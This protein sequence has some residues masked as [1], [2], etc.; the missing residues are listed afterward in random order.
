MLNLFRRI[1]F[2][3]AFVGLLFYSTAAFARGATSLSRDSITVTV[4]ALAPKDAPA[5]VIPQEDVTAFSGATRLKVTRWLRAQANEANLQLAVLIDNDIGITM[6]GEQMQDLANFI[7]SQPPPQPPLAFSTPK[8]ARRQ[9]RFG[10]LR[11]TQ[12]P[13]IPSA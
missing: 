5:P 10:S 7:N 8:T 4:T 6:M 1:G 2:A 3:C 9:R 11:T 13:P 12:R